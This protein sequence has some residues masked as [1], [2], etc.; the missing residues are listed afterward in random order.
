VLPS[1]Q[2]LI[3]GLLATISLEVIYFHPCALI[4]VF[5]AFFK[6]ILEVVFCE[7][8]QHCLRFCLIHFNCIKMV[9]SSIGEKRESHTG[10]SQMRRIGGRGVTV[11]LLL[12][13]C[14]D[15]KQCVVMMQQP[16]PLSPKFETKP[17]HTFMQPP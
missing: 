3:L 7:G 1:G 14:P 10:P 16:V 6:C 9:V 2:K 12:V 8:V 4:P 17:S 5:L 13:K 15:E 11:M